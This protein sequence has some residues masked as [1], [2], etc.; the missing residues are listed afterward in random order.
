MRKCWG[1][2]KESRPTFQ[3]LKEEFDGLISIAEGYKYIM[4][5]GN[6]TAEAGLI[7]AEAPIQEQPIKSSDCG[8]Q[9]H[10]ETASEDNTG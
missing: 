7:P 6:V 8:P 3:E 5:L 1:D 10:L 4:L 2:D 9:A